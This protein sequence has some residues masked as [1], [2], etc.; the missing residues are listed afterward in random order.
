MTKEETAETAAP[1]ESVKVKPAL[2]S[3]I[4][5]AVGEMKKAKEDRVAAEAAAAP[6]V[7]EKKEL[8]P[9]KHQASED[10]KSGDADAGKPEEKKVEVEAPKADAPSDSHIERAIKA[11]IPMAD[12]K[13][14]QSASALERV[15]TLMETRAADG[16]VAA[17]DKKD[18]KNAEADVKDPLE[19]I[20]DLDPEKYDE[21]VVAGFKAMKDIIRSQ[22]QVIQ[23]VKA[24]GVSRDG[25]W[26]DGQVAKLGEGFVEAVGNGDRSKLDPAGPQAAKRAALEDKFTV[27]SAGYK[28]AGK[29]IGREAVFGEAVSIVLGDVSAKVAEAARA[30]KLAKRVTQHVARPTGAKATPTPDVFEE[31]AAKLDR[32]FFSKK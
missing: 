16:K 19:S 15:C 1:A 23:S 10:G 21:Q 13:S 5:A 6:V 22:Q 28:A 31:T 26:F 20:P 8:P 11:G 29:D 27:L 3:E 7:P 4:N 24:D 32:K 2:A 18:G 9:A 12:A 17:G 30:E 25:S 14:F